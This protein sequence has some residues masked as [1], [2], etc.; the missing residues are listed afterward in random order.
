MDRIVNG[1]RRRLGNR[2]QE[3]SQ[4]E[5]NPG[6]IVRQSGFADTADKCAPLT[7]MDRIAVERS[8]QRDRRFGRYAGPTTFERRTDCL[9]QSMTRKG[10][11]PEIAR[12]HTLAVC[13]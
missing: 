6:E 10:L 2:H 11:G 3:L 1:L 4:I 7:Y 9:T 13:H 12:S 8:R 5:C